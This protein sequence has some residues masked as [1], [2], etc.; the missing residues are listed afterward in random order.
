MHPDEG[1]LQAYID[2]ELTGSDHQQ[3]AQHLATCSSCRNKLADIQDRLSHI[4]QS[5]NQLNLA[6]PLPRLSTSAARARLVAHLS[7]QEKP[8][9]FQRIFSRK[10]RP[11][12]TG[13]LIIAVLAIALAFPS[14]RVIANN[15]LGL[16]RAERITVVPVDENQLSER[17]DSSNQLESLFSDSVS[18]QGGGEIQKATDVQ[19]ASEMANLTVRL[20]ASPESP[21]QLFVQPGGSFSMVLD[22]RQARAVLEEIG[23]DEVNIPD[24]LD[25]E[26]VSVDIPDMVMAHYGDCYD[27]TAP[28]EKV[29]P[30][31]AVIETG[32]SCMELF[33]I[34]SPTVNAPPDLDIIQLGQAMLQVLGMSPEE[35]AQFSATV[36][37][38]T[39]L[40]LPVPRSMTTYQNI[41]VDGVPATLIVQGNPQDPYHYMLVWIKDGVVYGLSGDN[42]IDTAIEMANSMQ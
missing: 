31:Q 27:P 1:I 9:M 21:S 26:I 41:S 36:D 23:Q 30:D 29:D 40:V 16:F 22:V 28:R 4:Q 39:T 19:N 15:F 38:T 18:Y 17:L 42:N 20:P 5:L 24:T 25:G 12:W 34:H 6:P 13:G 32:K 37:W 7:E 8:N 33:Q 11:V 2:A 10:L 35:A 14:V 3:V